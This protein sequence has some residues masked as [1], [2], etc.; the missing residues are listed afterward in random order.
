MTEPE[1]DAAIQVSLLTGFLGS[2]KTTLLNSLLRHPDMSETAVLVNEFGDIGIDHALVDSV[3]PDMVQ[4][5]TGCLCCTVQGD[6]SRALRE[7]FLKRV[8]G[9][10]PKFRRVLIETT[11]LA[12]PAPAIHTLVNDPI[13]ETRF[14]LDGVITTIDAVHAAGQLDRHLECRKQ[15]AVAD[16][17]VLTK[18]DISDPAS[19][20]ALDSLIHGINPSAPVFR[21]VMGD[22]DPAHLFDCGLFNPKE[23][24][25]DVQAW[26][27][28]EAYAAAQDSS[29]HH[30][31]H[32]HPETN[33]HSADIRAFCMTH[34]KPISWPVFITWIQGLIDNYGEGLLRI[35]GIVNIE[36]EAQPVAIHGVQHVFHPPAKLPEWP[37]SRRDTRIVFILHQIDPSVIQQSLSQLEKATAALA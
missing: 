27:K 22:I 9:D 36:G 32:D 8:N 12:D 23:K 21:A 4:L 3:D 30:H 35:K 15:L 7:L 5:T 2:G 29:G 33:R 31:E 28:E 26:L 18:T 37:D 11:G 1:T 6:L 16:R 25:Y 19:G 20:K 17:I 34:E 13:I 14:C 24:T 10:V